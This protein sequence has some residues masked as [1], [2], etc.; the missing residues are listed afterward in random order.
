MD[1]GNSGAV[2]LSPPPAAD[3]SID[4]TVHQGPQGVTIC[5]MD[6]MRE[7]FHDVGLPEE[8]A[9]FLNELVKDSSHK[10]Y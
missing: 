5:G 9:R 4:S 10:A 3:P 2:P 6:I 8:I 7:C 1:G